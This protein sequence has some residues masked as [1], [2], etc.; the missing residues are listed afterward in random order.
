MLNQRQRTILSMLA[1]AAD[2]VAVN[3][4]ALRLGVAP[5]SVRADLTMVEAFVHSATPYRLE[6][7]KRR[8]A[9]LMMPPEDRSR[10]PAVPPPSPA[11]A[12]RLSPEERVLAVVTAL[13]HQKGLVTLDRLADQLHV[14]RR[15]VVED[16]KQ[17]EGWLAQ[18]G[19]RLRRLPRGLTIEGGEGPVRSALVELANAPP[20]TASVE[21]L[22]PGEMAVIEQAVRTAAQQLP[23]ELADVAFQALLYHLSVAVMRLRAG[24][25]IYMDSS[26]MA[27]LKQKPEWAVA[28]ELARSLEEAL[29]VPLPPDEC[30]YI[31][32]HLL[33]A[34]AVREREPAASAVPEATLVEAVQAFMRVAGAHLGVDLTDAE[35]LSGLLLHLRPAVYR[36]RYG[37]RM[38]NPLRDQIIERYGFLVAAAEAAVPELE[39]RLAIRI[40]PDELTYLAMHIGAFLE[41]VAA[42]L[43]VR[44]L[45]VCGSGIGTARLLEGRMQRVFPSIHIEDVVPVG[46]IRAHPALSRVQLVITTVPLSLDE[47]P[48]VLVNPFLTPEDARQIQQALV[49]EGTASSRER[50]RGPMLDQVLSPALIRLDLEAADWEEAIRLAGA[51]LVESNQVEPRYVDAMVET[52]RR[53]G[54]YI[55]VDKGI[56]MPHAR[57]EDGVR[58]V[59]FS[60]IR[61]RR[62]VQFGHPTNDP[63][64]LVVALASPDAGTHLRALQQLADLLA[65]PEARQIFEQGSSKEI[66]AL[67][68][69]SAETEGR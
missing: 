8:G 6:R 52:V 51:P 16:L 43:Q 37:L 65:C 40:P 69:Q 31:T 64:H 5:R 45:L 29:Q 49:V 58:E 34:K 20:V 35:L 12:Y 17:V 23:F 22:P 26:Q 57:P 68:R 66:L 50:M 27:D 32:L 48:V 33:G 55:V 39:R 36:L 21:L 38:V 14:S 15:T 10:W 42:R 63:V 25:E 30:G 13:L 18:R 47:V 62:P 7:N 61:L 19:L 44:V 59:A 56:A 4:L 67:I 60:L 46:R 9:R 53:I 24:N 41:R 11:A 54:P 1:Q 2:F 3:D 28:C